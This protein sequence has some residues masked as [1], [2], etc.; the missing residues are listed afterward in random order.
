M[1]QR[2][3]Q[4][5]R[6]RP[7]HREQGHARD[8]AAKRSTGAVAERAAAVAA[9]NRVGRRGCG[10]RGRRMGRVH[11]LA[12][13]GRDLPGCRRCHASHPAPR[14]KRVRDRL[15]RKR[16]PRQ[17]RQNQ[18]RA[19]QPGAMATKFLHGRSLAANNPALNRNRALRCRRWLRDRQVSRGCTSAPLAP[20]TRSSSE[21]PASYPAP[22]TSRLRVAG[23]LH[24]RPQVPCRSTL[25]P[26]ARFARGA[27]ARRTRWGSRRRH[28]GSRPA[29]RV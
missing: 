29:C 2:R 8:A 28:R 7:C 1:D 5:A 23:C 11:A 10:D 22:R 25:S 17:H 26:P 20:V 14:G 18:Q 19:K 13:H 4:A 9:F 15:E 21:P 3:R 27:A 12:M 6:Q 16:R 24:N